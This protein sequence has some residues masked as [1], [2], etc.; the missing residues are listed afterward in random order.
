VSYEDKA[1]T[2]KPDGIGED[3]R[4]DAHSLFSM[5]TA[6]IIKEKIKWFR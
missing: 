1:F 3:K 5:F 6:T 2:Q 4:I